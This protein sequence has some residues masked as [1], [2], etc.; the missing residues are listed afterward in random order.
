MFSGGPLP[1]PHQ[2]LQNTIANLSHLTAILPTTPPCAQIFGPDFIQ[3]LQ[4]FR[5]VD[6]NWDSIAVAA[7]RNDDTG[8]NG[9]DEDL[10][11]W[12]RIQG[13]YRSG[14]HSLACIF[15]QVQRIIKTLVDMANEHPRGSG[16]QL[17]FEFE[18]LMGLFVA[19]FDGMQALV[20]DFTPRE[21]DV[22][23]EATDM[24]RDMNYARLEESFGEPEEGR[25]LKTLIE[26]RD[27]QTGEIGGIRPSPTDVQ[28]A[29]LWRWRKKTGRSGPPHP[30][31]CDASEDRAWKPIVLPPEI[32]VTRPEPMDFHPGSGE[33]A[34]SK[35]REKTEVS[36]LLWVVVWTAFVPAFSW[37]FTA[38]S[39]ISL[40]G[41]PYYRVDFAM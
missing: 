25:D 9:S 14:K 32:K 37:L 40:F 34:L 39:G 15:V 4:I 35:S 26:S 29:A 36:Q 3:A 10:S 21:F 17:H 5:S 13:S 7:G 31:E 8:G 18:I 38:F 22:V 33:E 20:Q 28:R 16:M 11:R 24:V 19:V 1:N 27:P 41:L 6:E 12:H 23:D 2:Q 30:P